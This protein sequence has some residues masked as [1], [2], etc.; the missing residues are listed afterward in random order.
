A[1]LDSDI[2]HLRR[3]DGR[4][5]DAILHVNPHLPVK[6]LALV[7]NP[8]DEPVE[9]VLRLPLYYTGLTEVARIR[10]R[11]GE[12]QAYRLA[13]DYSVELPVS[14]PARGATWFLVT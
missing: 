6:G 3:P 2:L 11:E 12:A 7:Y 5:L 10:E 4:D 14:V 9:R 13:R 1:I 8:L